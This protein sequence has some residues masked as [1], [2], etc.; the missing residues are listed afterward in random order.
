KNTEQLVKNFSNYAF[1]DADLNIANGTHTID[2]FAAGWD[3][4]LQHS[5]F[6]LTVGSTPTPPV[7]QDFAITISPATATVRAGQ[8]ASYAVSIAAQNGFTGAV[9]LA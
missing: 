1:L 2:V 3:N 4:L 7:G 8:A 6:S 5:A 9:T